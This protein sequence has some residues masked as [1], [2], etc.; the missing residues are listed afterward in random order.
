MDYCF[1]ICD[2]DRDYAGYID[3]LAAQWARR[4]GVG[5][6]TERFPSAESFLF[7]YAERKDFDVL[8]LD[9]EMAGMDGVELAGRCQHRVYGLYRRGL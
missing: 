5:L 2:D 4:A 6:E 8:L 7:R 1:A 9:I 3:G